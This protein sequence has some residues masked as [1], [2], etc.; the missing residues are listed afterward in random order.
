MMEATLTMPAE[1]LVHQNELNFEFVGHYTTQCED[2]SSSALW[3]HVDTTSTIELAGALLP[4]QN[5][6]KLLPLPFYDASVNLH[7]IV[8]IVFLAQPSPKA[9]QAAGI[10]A[11]WFGILTD[12]R[13]VRFPVSFG[14]IPSGNVIV[15]SE[16]SAELPTSFNIS[17]SSGPTIAMRPNPSDP[18]SKLLVVSGDNPDDLVTAAMALTLQRDVLQGDQMRIANLRAP[19]PRDPDDAPRWLSTDKITHLGDIAQTGDL[20]GDGAVPIRAYMRLPPD[21]Y[22]GNKRNLSFHM[23]YRY[24]GI[25]ISNESSLQV[26]VNDG[27]VSSTPM[28]HTDRASAQL[29]TVIPVPI[30]NMRPFSNTLMMQ[31]IFLLPKKGRCQDTAPYNLKGAILKDSYLDIKDIPH[32]AVLPNLEI[33]ANAGYPFTR[34]ADLSDT[35]VVLPDTPGADEIEMYLTMMGHFGAQTGY[36]VLNV[37]VTNNDGMKADG[38]K[39]YLVMGTVED[40]PA[41]GRLNQVLPVVIDGSGLHIQDTAGLLR[42]GPARLV[43]GSELRS[44]A[45]GPARDR[46]RSARRSDRRHRVALRLRALCRDD[47]GAGSCRDSQL[48]LR[49][50]QELAVLR[51]RPVR[52][53]PPW[54]PLR[55]LPNRQR[56]VPR[57]FALA[58]GASEH[59]LLRVPVAD[60]SLLLCSVLPSRHLHSRD[61]PPPRPCPPPGQRLTRHDVTP[62]LSTLCV[63]AP[64]RQTCDPPVRHLRLHPLPGCAGRLPGRTALAAMAGIRPAHDRRRRAG[65]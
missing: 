32:W 40:Q 11:S 49:L 48:P 58:L 51:H 28:P 60:R 55:L 35:A 31:F 44:C 45:V 16:N 36:P 43:E 5:D 47:G 33:F 56:C 34:K 50:P 8:P 17:G 27:Y 15:I 52:Q 10:I 39:D 57:R 22:Y 12:F 14:T 3:S 42:A 19:A 18:Y 20:Q 29:E 7:P 24:N 46:R 61:A 25:P 64:G 37:T 65:P 13:P 2:P 30:D 41:L 1:M 21:L 6:L 4:L 59:A 9:M 53:R 54:L 38:Q 62:Y 26:S 63:D 23:N